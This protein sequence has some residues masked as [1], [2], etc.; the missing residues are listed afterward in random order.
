M[1]YKNIDYQERWRWR[2]L[3][4]RSSITKFVPQLCWKVSGKVI[5]I[6]IHVVKLYSFHG[7]RLSVGL[8]NKQPIYLKLNEFISG[9]SNKY[10]GWEMAGVWEIL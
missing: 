3:N 10:S 6:T 4:L 2:L 8:S 5:A 7:V 1:L 9:S